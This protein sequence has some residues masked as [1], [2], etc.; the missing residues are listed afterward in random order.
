MKRKLSI[1]FI[2]VLVLFAFY[3]EAAKETSWPMFLPGIINATPPPKTVTSAGKIWMDR[4]L[5]ATRVATTPTDQEAFGH[6]FQWG[7]SMDGHEMRT[8]QAI[9]LL[10]NA[11]DPGHDK[12]ILT[13]SSPFDWRVPQNNAFWQGA[14]GTNNPC[15]QGFRLPT[16][17]EFETERASWSSDNAAGAFASPLKL[18]LA[19]LRVQSDGSTFNLGSFGY[20]WTGTVSGSKSSALIFQSNG[21]FMSSANRA[22]GFS[23]RCIKD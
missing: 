22:S 16:S 21:A 19:G 9:P 20:Y 23:L 15:P 17:D 4:N 6:L 11:D 3:A 5:G 1:P 14:S 7:R 10:S 12:F 8:S 18:T 2:I 13:S